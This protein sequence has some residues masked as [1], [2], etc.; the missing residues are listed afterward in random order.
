LNDWHIQRPFWWEHDFE[1]YPDAMVDT[2]LNPLRFEAKLGEIIPYIGCKLWRIDMW[3]VVVVY[4]RV[5][6]M[7]I[8][9]IVVL[10]R[11]G[12]MD[13][14][15]HASSFETHEN[16]SPLLDIHCVRIRYLL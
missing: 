2:T 9:Y 7:K 14:A 11:N 6:V 12:S 15:W 4:V 1:R 13:L 10:L 8:I 16:R 3:P 5:G